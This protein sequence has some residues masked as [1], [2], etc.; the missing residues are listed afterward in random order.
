MVIDES[1]ESSD[2]D[3]EVSCETFATA[4]HEPANSFLILRENSILKAQTIYSKL[5]ERLQGILYQRPEHE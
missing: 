4:L 5:V 3:E 2:E 1:E